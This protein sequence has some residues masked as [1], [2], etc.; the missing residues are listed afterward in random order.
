[1]GQLNEILCQVNKVALDTNSF[2]YLL[3]A[4]FK[5]F[6][7]VEEIFNAIELGKVIG[8]TSTLAL[9]EVLTKPYKMGDYTLVN[10]YRILF[11]H[12]PNLFVVNV[13]AKIGETAAWLRARYD[14][15]APDAIFMATAIVKEADVFITNDEHL[16]RVNEIRVIYLNDYIT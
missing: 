13:D 3:E 12:F 1:M 11:K 7:I 8:I 16:K 5:W 15:K 9:T 14:L 2:I 4:N 6:K 10:E